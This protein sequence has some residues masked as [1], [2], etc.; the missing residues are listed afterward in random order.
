MLTFV[1]GHNNPVGAKMSLWQ[2]TTHSH[3]T[4]GEQ[5][6]PALL[7]ILRLRLRHGDM[8]NRSRETHQLATSGQILALIA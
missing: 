1:R 4:D 7:H 2:Q 5:E 6:R 3:T 8:L